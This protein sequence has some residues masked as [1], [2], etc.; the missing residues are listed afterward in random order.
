METWTAIRFLHV[1]LH[2]AAPHLRFLSAATVA[3]SVVIVSLG[4]ELAQG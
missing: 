3:L 4:V 1:G 2:A